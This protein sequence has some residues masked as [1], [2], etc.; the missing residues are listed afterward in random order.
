M[1][2]GVRHAPERTFRR[3]VWTLA[4]AS[5]ATV[6]NFYYN[7]PH[8]MQARREGAGL[9]PTLTQVGY[10]LGML[11][12]V[13]L[14]DARER[15][16]LV[17]ACIGAVSVA[18][19]A[20]ALSPNLPW[21]LAA[22]LAMGIAT[23]VPQILVP[24]AANLAPPGERGR[25]VGTVMSGL[26]SGILLSRTLSGF[27]GAAWG[28]RAMYLVAAALMIALAIILRIELPRSEA[29]PQLRYLAL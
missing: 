23:C 14:G 26:L 5:G 24:L 17:V 7:Q 19:L 4:I 13:P 27:L 16:S 8:C 25:A 15:R 28:W 3:L 2:E 20:I 10:G 21:L 1:V 29:H 22:S 9:V 11:L 18:L 12:V 6:A